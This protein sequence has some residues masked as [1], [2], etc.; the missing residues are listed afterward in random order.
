MEEKIE[1]KLQDIE[2][3]YE[4]EI[5]AARDFG[6]T[7]W[8]LDSEKS[9]RDVSFIFLQPKLEYIQNG[10]Y[11]ESIDIDVELNGKE[12]TFMGWNIK[13]FAELLTKSNPTVI[14]FLN[15]PVRYRENNQIGEVLENLKEHSSQNF[16][17]IALFY[18]YRSMAKSNYRRYLENKKDETIKRNLYVIRGLLYSNYIKNT[19]K[20]P[21]LDF[22]DF[23]SKEDYR[24]NLREVGI[25]EEILDKAQEYAEMKRSGK[26]RKEIGNPH[27]DWIEK[28]LEEELDK[29]K[30]DV[31]GIDQK[32]VNNAIEQVFDR[33]Q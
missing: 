29:K 15:S 6:S 33:V 24:K 2:K 1:E 17:P 18:H 9:D 27:R 30:H 32:L 25:T 5:I 22:W 11:R 7:A 8:N 16:K 19:H 14:E 3:D 21:P 23:I 20:L 10:K 12:H 26:G 13:R 28:E 31:R 4:V